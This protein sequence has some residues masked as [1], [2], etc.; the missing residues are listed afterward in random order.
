M[1]HHYQWNGAISHTAY[2]T[3]SDGFQESVGP[4]FLKAGPLPSLRLRLSLVLIVK[5]L[6]RPTL[7]LSSEDPVWTALVF[8]RTPSMDMD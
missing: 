4:S 2:L 5:E 7:H 6:N 8:R 3:K 1:F